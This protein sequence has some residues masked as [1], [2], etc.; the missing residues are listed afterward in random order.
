MLIFLTDGLPT[1]GVTD[2]A[3]IAA[4]AQETNAQ[5]EAR[6]HVF[7]VGYDVNT[8]LLDQL[9]GK[10]GGS[11]TYVQPGEDLELVLTNFYRRIAHPVLT[12]LQIEF[13]GMEVQD[14]HPQTLP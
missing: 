2:V 9:A 4:R 3:S 12:D 6:L 11:V 10:N 7:G 8:H 14:L 1:A 13:E 5:V